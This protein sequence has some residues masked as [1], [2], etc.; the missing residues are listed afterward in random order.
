MNKKSTRGKQKLYKMIGC[1]RRH[2]HT[3]SCH[4]KKNRKY[5]KNICHKCKKHYN[6]GSNPIAPLSWS[7]MNKFGG[8]PVPG[9]FVGSPWGSNINEWPGMDGISGNRN[10]LENY[11]DV[12]QNDPTRQMSMNA[13]GLTQNG[14][15]IY[16]KSS[17]T[18]SKTR[19]NKGQVMGGGLIPQ[20]LVNLG[21]DIGFNVKSAYNAL[22][23]YKPPVDPAPYKDQL[24]SNEVAV[25]A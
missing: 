8:N 2:R 21:R 6:G 9:P 15:Y 24:R 5:R 16:E 22:N 1:S 23:G 18:G 11:K 4:T 7:K 12:I 19:K 25:M 17:S 3:K 20:D 10:Y 14:G 13:S